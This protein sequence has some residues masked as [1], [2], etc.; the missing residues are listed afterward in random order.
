VRE[1]SFLTPPPPPPSR[2]TSSIKAPRARQ[3]APRGSLYVIV[4]ALLWAPDS[5]PSPRFP[6]RDRTNRTRVAS[7]SPFHSPRG[8]KRSNARGTTR[9]S[10]SAFRCRPAVKALVFPAAKIQ[11][12]PV[13]LFFL[14]GAVGRRGGGR[15]RANNTES[16]RRSGPLSDLFFQAPPSAARAGFLCV[17]QP[18]PPRATTHD[19]GNSG[20][21]ARRGGERGGGGVAGWRRLEEVRISNPWTGGARTKARRHRVSNAAPRRGAQK[22]SY[23]RG[24][25]GG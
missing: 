14:R 13:L 22:G 10:Y 17:F 24:R 15:A 11:T 12:H 9:G 16:R 20:W 18:R 6:S 7:A 8:M 4:K 2:T 1:A 3:R 5:S 23:P 25:E 19:L 21:A